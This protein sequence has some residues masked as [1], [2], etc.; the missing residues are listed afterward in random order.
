MLE[1]LQCRVEDCDGTLDTTQVIRLQTGCHHTSPTFAC[2]QCGRIHSANGS[3][4][5]N[6]A[7]QEAGVYLRAGAVVLL[8]EDGNEIDMF[9]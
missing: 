5:V 3:F 6:R 2:A 4:M 1:E 9:G 8:D 7:Y